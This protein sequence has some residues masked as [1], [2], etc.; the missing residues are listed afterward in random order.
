LRLDAMP[1]FATML[2]QR[3]GLGLGGSHFCFLFYLQD[4]LHGNRRHGLRGGLWYCDTRGPRARGRSARADP[5][6]GG[7]LTTPARN[8]ERRS[9]SL[10]RIARR[11]GPRCEGFHWLFAR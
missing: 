8:L 1:G 5:A 7:I 2:A 11:A 3:H 10:L 6:L 9:L 4:V